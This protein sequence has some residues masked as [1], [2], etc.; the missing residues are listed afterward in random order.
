[1]TFKV[2]G[3]RA[4]S[5]QSDC[6]TLGYV[7]LAQGGVATLAVEVLMGVPWFGMKISDQ[8]VPIAYYFSIKERD[9]LPGP[10]SSKFDGC[11]ICVYIIYEF[12]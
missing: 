1:M 10:L 12:Y 2:N 9:R 3:L 7:S 11:M 8:T 4:N 6:L 5:S